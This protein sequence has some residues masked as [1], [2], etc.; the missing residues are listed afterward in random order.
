MS[1]VNLLSKGGSLKK[2]LRNEPKAYGGGFFVMGN[3]ATQ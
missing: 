2:M 3:A 1:A